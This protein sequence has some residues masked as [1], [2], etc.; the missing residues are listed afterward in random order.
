M[1]ASD[2]Y[3]VEI[4][5]TLQHQGLLENTLVIATSDH[6]EM[7][8]THGGM[9]QKC[10]N[11]YEETLRVPLVYSNPRLF[12][13]PRASQALVSHVDFLST[14]A[15]LFAVPGEAR[16][17][18]AG[19]DYSALV[20]ESAQEAYDLT[21]LAPRLAE[22]PDV[23]LPVIVCV[24]GFTI[25][26]SAEPVVL[27]DDDRC[28]PSSASTAFPTPF[29]TS[30]TRPPKAR[31][32][33]RTTTTSCAASRRPRSRARCRSS[34]SSARELGALTGRMVGAVERVPRRGRRR[35]ARLPRVDGRHGEGRRRRAA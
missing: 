13:E 17:D 19:V 26:H 9:R 27:L 28:T 12:P 5:D 14:L 6:G 15:G 30:Q 2:N 23:L 8:L 4:L 7:G 24:D 25:T 21:V 22:H 35:R 34:R 3:L 31:S 11:F 18:W 29:S 32:R 10:F 16:T 33:C 20:L 1:T